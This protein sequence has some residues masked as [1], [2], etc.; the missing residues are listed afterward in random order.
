MI[1]LKTKL[2]SFVEPREGIYNFLPP[3]LGKIKAIE[4]ETYSERAAKFDEQKILQSEPEE[5]KLFEPIFKKGPAENLFLELGGGDGRFA[6]ALMR[7]GY[8]IVET[9]IAP[10]SVRKTK[11]MAEK[12]GVANQNFF[13]TLDAENLPFKDQVLD[14]V[15]M[16]AT[17]HHLPNYSRALQEIFRVTKPGGCVLILREPA[18]WFSYL[19]RPLILLLRFLIR[20]INSKEPKSLADDLTLGFSRRKLRKIFEALGF[21]EIR[22]MPVDYSKKIYLNY[23]YLKARL[24]KK[25][26]QENKKIAA[27]FKKI[28]R[29]IAKIPLVNELAWDWDCLMY[30]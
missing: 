4:V 29:F 25:P 15:F 28:D 21:K 10:G 9:D 12:I 30:R 22:I 18:S 11:E 2:K 19:F 1:D 3:N 13:M 20:K 26:Y 27:F 14:G 24:F 17:F 7:R 23:C 5:L 6:L 16:V 8:T